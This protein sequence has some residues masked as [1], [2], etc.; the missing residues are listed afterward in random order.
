[1]CF[2]FLEV[3]FPVTGQQGEVKRLSNAIDAWQYVI[4]IPEGKGSAIS[5]A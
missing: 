5:G 4:Q 2:W 3:D 1:M